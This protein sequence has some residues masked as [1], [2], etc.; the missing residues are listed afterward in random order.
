MA[1]RPGRS[2]APEVQGT[3]TVGPT[4]ASPADDLMTPRLGTATSGGGAEEGCTD[5]EATAW[6]GLPATRV[7]CD[8]ATGGT[9][10]RLMILSFD[11][12]GFRF[13]FVLAGAPT[14]TSAEDF[15]ALVDSLHPLPGLVTGAL[16]PTLPAVD[17]MRGMIEGDRYVSGAT[18]VAVGQTRSWTFA[19]APTQADLGAGADIV[20]S[21]LDPRVDVV[22]ASRRVPSGRE[23]AYLDS[24]AEMVADL[25][26]P[27]PAGAPASLEVGGRRLDLHRHGTSEQGLLAGATCQGGVC[28]SIHAGTAAG[29]APPPEVLEGFP[30]V[31]LLGNEE[32]GAVV[33]SLMARPRWPHRWGE[34]WSFRSG[35]FTCFTHGVALD[36]PPGFYDLVPEDPSQGILASFEDL[37]S[38]LFVQLRAVPLGEGPEPEPA[39]IHRDSELLFFGTSF[40]ASA[41]TTVGELPGRVSTGAWDPPEAEHAWR[42]SH[43]RLVTVIRGDHVLGLTTCAHVDELDARRSAMDSI[44]A[45]WSIAAAPGDAI[46]R[47]EGRFT[48]HRLGFSID[49]PGADFAA[50]SVTVGAEAA[51]ELRSA[52]GVYFSL[53]DSE[54]VVAVTRECPFWWGDGIGVAFAARALAA[55]PVSHTPPTVETVTIDDVPFERFLWPEAPGRLE[56]LRGCRDGLGFAVMLVHRGGSPWDMDITSFAFVE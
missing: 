16:Q 11:R 14:V 31:E 20:L 12:Q 36:L 51:G 7:V 30:P 25:V 37:D 38:G 40:G 52:A 35:R 13:C 49:D 28:V 53:G 46:E 29:G 48:D 1:Y 10:L 15:R 55:F 26:P 5:R 42:A 47:G 9:L 33:E 54:L 23:E 2:G 41:P 17:H 24:Y 4:P 21:R 3:L 43:C 18:G 34:G 32:R 22:I 50:Q 27:D 6:R 19:R 56:V 8:L 45:G 44:A 39:A